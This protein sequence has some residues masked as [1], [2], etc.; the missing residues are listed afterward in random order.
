MDVSLCF[1]GVWQR[2]LGNRRHLCGD[3]LLSQEDADAPVDR[4]GFEGP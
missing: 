3:R 4:C 1:V 2:G